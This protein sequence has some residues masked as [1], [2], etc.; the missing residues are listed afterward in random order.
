MVS[1]EMLS[2]RERRRP[3]NL[4]T[5]YL[6]EGAIRRFYIEQENVPLGI[7]VY[8]WIKVGEYIG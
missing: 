4:S 6:V 2:M 8:L 7:G 1:P 3:R 5:S